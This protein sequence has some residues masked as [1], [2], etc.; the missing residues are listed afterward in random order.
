MKI[1]C[2]EAMPYASEFFERVGSVEFFQVGKINKDAL[3]NTNALLVRSTTPINEQLLQLTP[4]LEFVGTA[5]AGYNHFDVNAITAKGIEWTASPGCN[6]RG[7]A[8]YLIAAVLKLAVEDELTLVDMTIAVVG[9]GEVG[10]RV[11]KLCKALDMKVVQYDPPKAQREQD[12]VSDEWH[13]VLSAN[14]ISLHMPLVSSGEHQNV[15]MFSKE[16]LQQLSSHQYLINACRGEVI[17]SSALF[18]MST[19]QQ[20]VYIFD[21][22]ENEP[23]INRQL[24]PK[25]RMGTPHIAGHSLEGKARGTEMLYLRLCAK[26]GVEPSVELASLLPTEIL[27]ESMQHAC[28]SINQQGIT[29]ETLHTLVKCFYDIENDDSFFRAHMAKFEAITELRRHYPKRREFDSV[30]LPIDSK[31]NQ[32]RLGLLGFKFTNDS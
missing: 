13:Q 20:P 31:E 10:G 15:H 2:D 28:K 14:I 7:V 6:A 27:T 24:I 3:A 1:L 25:V 22:W 29:N 30:R 16:V 26:Y 8:E 5:T 19:E 12:F 18:D 17:D 21:C 4:S 9:V 11:A 32:R 23:N